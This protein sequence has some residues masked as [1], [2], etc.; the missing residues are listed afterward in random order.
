MNC[1][2]LILLFAT[3][4]NGDFKQS[5]IESTQ[6]MELDQYVHIINVPGQ[7]IAAT[8]H[9]INQMPNWIA[10]SRVYEHFHGTEDD[11]GTLIIRK[12]K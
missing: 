9:L 12:F 2:T 8:K 5:F 3:L 7:N 10:I 6:Y 11:Y 1:A 4:N